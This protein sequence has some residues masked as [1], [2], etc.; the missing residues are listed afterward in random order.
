[1]PKIRII[2][3]APKNGKKHDLY[4]LNVMIEKESKDGIRSALEGKYGVSF[5][6][7]TAPLESL[8]EL[9]VGLPY[10]FLAYNLK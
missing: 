4:H 6:I 8:Y 7:H 1:M 5:F 9:G 2:G 3:V 10:S